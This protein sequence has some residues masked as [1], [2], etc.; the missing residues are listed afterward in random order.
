MFI[1]H[2]PLSVYC[3]KMGEKPLLSSGRIINKI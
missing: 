3:F 2:F 1:E